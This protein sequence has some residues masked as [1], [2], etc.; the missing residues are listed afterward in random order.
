M[1]TAEQKLTIEQNK[2]TVKY[3]KGET[4]CKQGS[5]ASHVLFLEKGLVKVYLEGK[6]KNLILTIVPEGQLIGLH[7][8]FDGNNTF[9]YSVTTYVDSV[10]QMIN[11]D[12]IKQMISDNAQFAGQIINIL[13]ENTAQTY[14]RFY[15]LMQKQLHGRMADILL[16]LSNRIFKSK[17]FQLPLSRNDLGELTGMSTE[18]V[19]RIFKDFKDEKLISV[20]A[21]SIE[22]LNEEKLLMIS[23]KG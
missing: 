5:Q 3:N 16:C 20:N 23:E 21:K 18:S 14:G 12:V 17:S 1:L 7:A 11:S 9:I 13:N 10:V 6:P 4:I 15:C 19:I 8:I 22:I 2:V